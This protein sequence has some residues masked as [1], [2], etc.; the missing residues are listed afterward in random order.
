MSLAQRN[1]IRHLTFSLP[2]GQEVSRAM[3]IKPLEREHLD[4]LKQFKVG[5]EVSTPLWFYI[6][7]EAEVEAK[8]QHLGPLGGRI[9]AEVFVGILQGDRQ[10][11][12]RQ[13]PFW[14]PLFGKKD[15]EFGIA[16]LLRFA[17]VDKAPQLPPSPSPT[18][19]PNWG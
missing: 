7:R 3:C 10:S 12:L 15:G 9:V 11:Y 14:Q 5:F 17:K 4:D 8:G 19:P 13:D 2:S 6:L 16:D 18:P 1:L